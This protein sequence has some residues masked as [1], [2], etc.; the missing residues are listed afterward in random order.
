[1][2]LGFKQ[3]TVRELRALGYGRGERSFVDAVLFGYAMPLTMLVLYFA[4]PPTTALTFRLFD[5]CTTFTDEL[6][7]SQ[8]FLISDRKHYAVPC[9][10]DELEGAQSMSW[11]AIFMVCS[12]ALCT[13]PRHQHADLPSAPVPTPSPPCF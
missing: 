5:D 6:G 11:L 9:P 10:S 12:A 13:S 4:F 1:M 7:E 2:A 3:T 8:A